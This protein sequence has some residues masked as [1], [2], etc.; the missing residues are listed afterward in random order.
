MSNNTKVIGAG[1]ANPLIAN[2]PGYGTMRLTGEGF[3]GEPKDRE[4]AIAIIRKAVDMG[5][6]FFDTADFYGP[7][8]TNRLLAEAL[9][10][11]PN[12][13]I[14]ATKVGAKRGNDKS[15]LPYGKPEELRQSV[16]NNLRE[17]KME[18]LHLVHYGKATSSQ[19]DYEEGFGTMLELQ[20]EGKIAHL[21]LS[22]AT[23]DQL[24]IALKM[25]KIAS[26]ENLYSYSQRLT[27]PGSPFGFQG[28][29]VLPLCDE[30]KIIF[31]PFFSLQTS[32][33]SEQSKMKV[34]ADAKGVTVAQLNIAWLLHKSPV[35]LPI[36]GTTS[37]RHLEENIKAAEISLSEEDLRILG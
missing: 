11:Y 9:Y 24:N 22:N 26:V 10:P 16:E 32:L 28:G 25:G 19:E 33:P 8:V 31:I 12:N 27:D 29:E 21:G 5:V 35:I 17:L 13:L 18:Q 3:Y 30:H 36:P 4:G 15:W 1:A 14:I 6:N 2:A 7:G 34:I 37:I 23:I 20:K